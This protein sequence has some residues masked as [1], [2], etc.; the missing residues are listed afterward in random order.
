MQCEKT[1]AIRQFMRGKS[2][3]LFSSK[4]LGWTGLLLEQHELS[5]GE[6]PAADLSGLILCL[7]DHPDAN[8]NFVPRLI[9]SGTLSLYTAGVLPEVRPSIPSSGL[10]CAFDKDF[11]LEVPEEIRGESNTR[12]MADGMIS[13]DKRCFMDVPLQRIL[14]ALGEEA[15]SGGLLAAYMP[16][17]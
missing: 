15:R 17:N 4:G 8:G 10:I 1:L 16:T 5:A 3:R 9:H 13:Q 11:Q 12:S 7:C 14:E 2:R 6:W